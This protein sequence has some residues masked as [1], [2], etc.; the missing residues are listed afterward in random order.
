[1]KKNPTKVLS[2]ILALLLLLTACG[3][4]ASMV[5]PA[6]SSQSYQVVETL[7]PSIGEPSET[8]D[9]SQ[10]PGETGTEPAEGNTTAVSYESLPP[11]SGEL[12]TVVNDN[13]PGFTDADMTTTSFETYSPLDSMGRVGVAYA[14][15]GSDLMP[16]ET[17]GNISSVK[18]TGWHSGAAA[19]WNRSH[20]IGWQLSGENANE[21]NLMTGTRQFNAAGMLPFENMVADYIHE[22]DNH[23]LYRVTPI[24]VGSDLVA[25]GVQMEGYSVEDEG[26][27]IYFN[28]FV[29][30]NQ[31]GVTIDYGTGAS[32]ETGNGPLSNEGGANTAPTQQTGNTAIGKADYILNTNTKKFHYPS[33]PSV[34]QMNPSNR[35]EFF[36]SREDVL[37]KSYDPCG[38]CNP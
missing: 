21:R 18:P 31:P 19:N 36:G 34:D 22:T 8:A 9:V 24:F 29:Y 14:C 16:T 3:E 35:E 33:C 5:A 7:S 6:S 17:R 2:F 10:P 27:G 32:W 26:D 37:A 4:P 11:Y 13:I 1:M 28:V 20:L 30:N 12:Y 15:L 25:R 38:R 23:V